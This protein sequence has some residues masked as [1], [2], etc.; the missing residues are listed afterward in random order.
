MPAGR[1]PG[2]GGARGRDDE[3]A[4]AALAESERDA[5]RQRAPIAAHF[6]FRHHAALA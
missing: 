4:A 5:D 1:R 3:L 6:R 2:L